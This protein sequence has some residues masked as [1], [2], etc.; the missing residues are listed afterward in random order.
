MLKDILL[1]EDDPDVREALAEALSE[2]GYR[3]IAAAGGQEALDYLN[4][5][6]VPPGLI[7]LDLLMPVMDGWEFRAQLART[8]SNADIPVVVLSA[9]TVPADRME[10]LGARDY[11][12]KPINLA[13]LRAVA[14]RF[15]GK[16]S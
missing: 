3:V 15:S 5:A 6:R 1:I 8:G 12:R 14:E 4:T 10:R 11:L 2:V 16:P 7:L 13:Q 9:E